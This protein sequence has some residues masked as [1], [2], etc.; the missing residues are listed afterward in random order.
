MEQQ[1]D[2]LLK[3]YKQLIRQQNVFQIQHNFYQ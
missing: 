2:K 3:L 1:S